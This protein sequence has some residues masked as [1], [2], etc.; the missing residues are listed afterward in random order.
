[1][2]EQVM[3]VRIKPYNPKK[4][5]LRRVHIDNENNMRFRE[6]AGWYEVPERIA[7][8]L[9]TELQNPYDPDSPEVFDVCTRAAAL[10]IEQFEAIRRQQAAAT[11]EE[12]IRLQVRRKA[13]EGLADRKA[14]PQSRRDI[15]DLAEE[16]P[17]RRVPR[18]VTT[19]PEEVVMASRKAQPA[20]AQEPDY[21]VY[22]DEDGDSAAGTLDQDG[23]LDADLSEIVAAAEPP[24]ASLV[25]PPKRGR[26]RPRLSG[27]TSSVSG[28]DAD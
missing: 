13:R 20:P 12:P 5:H 14:Q 11:A 21:D 9:R 7:R 17:S 6:G 26:G 8:K 25:K 3:L 4:G 15:D 19:G 16:V 23:D 24:V 28:G 10:E 1:M 18:I 27:V 2:A 22:R